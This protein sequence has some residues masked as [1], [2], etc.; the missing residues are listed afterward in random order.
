[1]NRTWWKFEV[2]VISVLL[3]AVTGWLF[4]RA[5]EIIETINRRYPNLGILGWT[6]II[7]WFAGCLVLIEVVTRLCKKWKWSRFCYTE[8]M[9]AGALYLFF[10][11]VL[12][13]LL[14][15]KP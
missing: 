15:G 14:A 1:M 4:I 11:S 2:A 3:L 9:A 8:G 7:L 12:F 10:S 13:L 6:A 5:P